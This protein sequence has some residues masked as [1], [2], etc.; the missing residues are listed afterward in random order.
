MAQHGL[1][2]EGHRAAGA[3]FVDVACRQVAEHFGDPGAEYEAVRKGAGLIDLSHQ[4]KVRISGADRQDFLNRMLTNDIKA[5]APGRGC[6][7]FLLNAK[8]HVV[9]YLT[10]LALADAFLAE[11]DPAAAA[12]MVEMLGHYIVAD[13]VILED[14][15]EAWGLLSLQ[16]PAA[17]AVLQALLG[18]RAPSLEPFQHAEAQVG[19][20]PVRVV[21]HS[22]TGEKGYDLWV[23]ADRAAAPWDAA[24]RAGARHGLRPVGLAALNVLRLEAGQAWGSD[25]AGDVLA[26]ET[27][28]EGVISFSKGCYIGQEFVVRVA[29]RGHVNRKLSGLVLNGDR[30]PAAGDKVVQGER[31]AGWI[32]SAALSPALERPIALGYVRRE[33]NAPGSKVAV[34]SG[35]SLLGAEVVALPFVHGFAP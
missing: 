30:V 11:V 1:L 16:G 19:R 4:G 2:V 24:M 15:S 25:V 9:A 27:G 23:A 35:G 7:T 21:F 32:T 26:M 14:I 22:R 12:A 31:E 34:Q 17:P 13:D 6:Q 28:L 3:A 18:G 8:G 5:L 29:H 20:A 10:L 33:C